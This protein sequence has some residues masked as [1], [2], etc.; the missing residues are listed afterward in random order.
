MP[1]PI[2]GMPVVKVVRSR[3]FVGVRSVVTYTVVEGKK[4]SGSSR[5]GPLFYELAPHPT[6]PVVAP[7]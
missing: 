1:G 6:F 7:P 5:D 4:I 3:K 2:G